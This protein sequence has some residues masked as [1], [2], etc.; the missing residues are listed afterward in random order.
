M[1]IS[2]SG[3]VASVLDLLAQIEE[4]LKKANRTN[5][6]ALA[7]VGGEL[8]QALEQSTQ[9]LEAAAAGLGA[10]VKAEFS[11]LQAR[12][13]ETTARIVEQSDHSEALHRSI[14]ARLESLE[15]EQR[16]LAST[17]QSLRKALPEGED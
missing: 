5:P 9:R 15:N 7:A 17:L 8:G 1:K 12:V 10:L 2:E 4:H 16:G 14:A 13:S 3:I 6:A 11:A